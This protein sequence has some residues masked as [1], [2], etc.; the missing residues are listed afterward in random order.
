[1]PHQPG[2]LK[3]PF[4]TAIS[5]LSSWAA[6]F[7]F[8]H[9]RDFLVFWFYRPTKKTPKGY[10]PIRQ[11]Y[12]DF[13]TRRMYY[14]I[15]D[16]FNRPI[17]SAPN[18]EM[19]VLE[20]TSTV[21]GGA[22]GTQG[23]ELTGGQKDV[24]NLGSYN[25]LG[26]AAR[27]DYCTP[28]VLDTLKECGWSTC[29]SRTQAGS[30]PIH[31]QLERAIAD[32]LG[33][34]DAI[35]L[36]M[37]FATN[38]MILPALIGKG[39]L[40]ISDAL[41]HASIVA[42]VRGS[43]AKVKVFE[44]N[45]PDSLEAVLRNAIAQG[46]PRSGR[47]WK[48]V[49]IVTEGIF[50]M[51]GEACELAGIVAVAKKYKAYVFLD[52]AHSIGAL[53]KT[54][55]GIT[56]HA[57]VSTSD[58]DVMMGTFTKSFGAAGGYIASSRAVVQHLRDTSPAHISATAMSPPVA[59][60]IIS[61]L[62]LI[63]GRDD[64]GDGR[65]QRKMDQLKQ[66][67]NFFRE[68]LEGMG[69]NVLGDQDSPVMPIMLFQPAKIPAFSRLCLQRGVAVVVVGFPAT[70]LLSARC[71]ICIS[72]SH[73]RAQLERALEVIDEVADLCGLKHFPQTKSL[74]IKSKPE[75]ALPA[76]ASSL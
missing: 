11:D 44:H 28:R 15:H 50:S 52:E 1:M 67:A 39:S 62:T 18:S 31:R 37:G 76:A 49:L 60:Q 43:G 70:P 19:K 29:A 41:N 21:V 12:E 10:A 71:R 65:G 4:V 68:G 26:F 47:A 74:D 14:R 46:Q 58:I 64:V 57:G 8:G 55:R 23:L 16:A 27:D 20:R 48:K 56:E 38:S 54:G 17:A 24:L 40:I 61:A 7:I 6:F 69:L 5:T 13:Y 32:F 25:Y 75:L 33:K 51:E 59:Q 73:T 42:G 2:S 45:N 9:F 63:Q 72:A 30:S 22:N 3:P 34:E 66:N 35:V 53:G 36:G